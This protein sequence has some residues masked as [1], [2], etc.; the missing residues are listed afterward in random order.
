MNVHDRLLDWSGHRSGEWTLDQA[1]RALASEHSQ[2]AVAAAIN[3]LVIAGRI[4]QRLPRTGP[5]RYRD[6]LAILESKGER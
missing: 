5:M 1:S 2:P 6:A 4:R 3:R